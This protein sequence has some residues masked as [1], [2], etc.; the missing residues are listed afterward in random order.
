MNNK[1]IKIIPYITDD[2]FNNDKL[3]FKWICENANVDIQDENNCITGAIFKQT[4]EYSM[5]LKVSDG[6]KS[7]EKMAF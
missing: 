2:T 1:Y 5:L 3:E 6:E 7:I 4:G